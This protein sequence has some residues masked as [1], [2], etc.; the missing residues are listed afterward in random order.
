MA[1]AGLLPSI[2]AT[3]RHNVPDAV[4]GR[5]LGYATSAQFAGQVIG[6]V[7]GGFV[8]GHLGMRAVFLATTVLIFGGALYNWLV[9]RAVGA[10]P[11][12]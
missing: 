11:A 10:R 1:L 2:N 6:P 9:A 8:G 5:I 4:A 12:L 3:I 7:V